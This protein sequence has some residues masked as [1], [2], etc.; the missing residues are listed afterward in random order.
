MAISCVLHS[1]VHKICCYEH[2]LKIETNLEFTSIPGRTPLKLSL[3]HAV[4][5]LFALFNDNCM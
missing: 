2:H 4:N 5:D 1:V 3:D